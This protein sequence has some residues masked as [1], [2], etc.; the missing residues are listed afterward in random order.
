MK[1]HLR[2]VLMSSDVAF[3]GFCGQPVPISAS[4]QIWTENGR[5]HGLILIVNGSEVRHA[6]RR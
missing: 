1:K 5:L 2:E 3:C 6:C 4:M